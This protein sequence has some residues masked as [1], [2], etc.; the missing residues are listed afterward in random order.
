MTALLR[1]VTQDARFG[2]RELLRNKGFTATALL[3]LSLG[4]M[5]ATAMYSVI[6][7]VVIEPFPY[8]DVDNLVTIAIRNP[9]QR[10][11]RGNYNTDEYAELA[12]RATI[13]DGVAA[14][15]ISDVLWMSNGEPQRL[16]GNHISVNGFDV[17][18]V[19]ALLGRTVSASEELPE[20]KVVLGYRFWVR[21]F[22]GNTSIAG[23]TLILNG[24][25]RT[26]VGVM[27][28]RFMFRGADVYLPLAYRP[29][30]ETEGVNSV[31]ITARRKKG[32]TDAH[33]QTDI[34]PI[35][36]DLASRFPQRYP[37]KWRIEL[38][39]FKETFPSGIRE[40]LWMM[41]GA[42]ALLLL[43]ACANVSNLLLARASSRGREMAM[44]AAL[45]AGRGRLMRQLFTESL[46]LG[47]MGGALGIAGSWGGLRAIMAV[48][49]AGVIPDE[50][51]VLLNLPVLGFS[52]ALC[53]VTT[54]LFGLAPAL[55]ASGGV[56]ANPLREAGR[57]QAGSRRMGRFRDLL[58]VAELSLAIVLLAGAGFYLHTLLRLYNA[59]LVVGV[60]NRLTMRLPL[61]AQ[62]YPTVEK[63]SAF[64]AQLLDRVNA[65][66]G[67]RAAAVN[68]GLHPLGSWDFPVDIPGSPNADK[69][70]ASL[71]QV[72]ANYLKT[73]GIALRMGRWLTSADVAT[74]R[75]V[76]VVNE[77]FVRRYFPSDSPLG[78]SVKMARL[79]MP[80]FSVA[81]DTFEIA[82][83]A[84]NALH[85]LQ[86]GEARPEMYIPYSLTGLA[87]TLVVHT[88][89]D[90]MRMAPLIRAQVYQLD[91]AQYVDETR[92][93]E[94]LMDR[95]VYSRGRF[96]V[97]L[98]G[99][100]ASLGLALSVIGIYGLLAHAVSQQRREFG[101]R[102]AVGASYGDIAALVLFRGA[103]LLL[104]GLIV[105]VGFA[106]LFF[107]RFGIQLD[108]GSQFD[109]ASLAG[110]CVVLLLTGLMA[111]LIPALRAARTEPVEALRVE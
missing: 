109:V 30:E 53:L 13:F 38:I 43:I 106:M 65:M 108:A 23:T 5:A 58:V 73:T 101:V 19:P 1:A 14:S 7:G 10:G 62:R 51:E 74:A 41:F 48:V 54:L 98:M 17:M 61:S 42:V 70:P 28:P 67:V 34:D 20:T 11:W 56:L 55:H 76:V 29:G 83:V 8:K 72:D 71:H 93:L 89:G 90:P 97:W 86:N 78:K 102:M 32:I 37:P 18:G 84:Q 110:A 85:E 69:R 103:R 75:H 46:L 91:A 36:R 80:P 45:G 24:R 107:K 6:Y 59:P 12:R 96:F 9:E 104:A 64:L 25:P 100:F 44:R 4:I 49:P 33:A 16:R 35:I 87:A 88:A 92:T 99:A 57:G 40:I 31:Q 63:R 39:T 81:D 50:S 21:Q 60:E 105:G 26:I 94:F 2:M 3:S 95:Y 15:T 27:P 66:P 77:A 111:S 68:T 22:G 82:G 79:K 47:M 52:F